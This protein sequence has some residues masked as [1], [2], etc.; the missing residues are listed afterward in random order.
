[1][2]RNLLQRNLIKAFK[3]ILSIAALTA[4]LTLSAKATFVVDDNPSH[5]PSQFLFNDTAHRN[6]S[7]F[8]GFVGAN[9]PSAPTVHIHGTGNVSSG[10]GF[11]NIKPVHGGTLT[12]LIFT[13]ADNT[14]FGDFSFRGQLTAAGNGT[15]T[16]IVTDSLGASQ[17]FTFTGLGQNTDFA[18]QGIISSDETIQSVEL[19]SDFKEVK[20]IEFSL[21]G[22]PPPPVP[23]G[24]T[25]VMLLGAA[26][27]SL[28]VAR[29]FFKK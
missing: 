27:C 2:V 20:L 25:T 23:D 5:D 12:D 29:R 8:D 6:V 7:D 28:G 17:T 21:A 19:I 11:A 9:N 14:L 4:A 22:A 10:S 26:L 3:L 15:V 24:G 16:L 18:R 13:P 1:M